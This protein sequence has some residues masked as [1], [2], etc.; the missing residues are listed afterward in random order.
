MC[1]SI[2]S[3]VDYYFLHEQP[4]SFISCYDVN[5]ALSGWNTNTLI[6][7]T[8]AR[9]VRYVMLSFT[10]LIH[11]QCQCASGVK[12]VYHN[13]AAIFGACLPMCVMFYLCALKRRWNWLWYQNK[14]HFLLIEPEG[15]RNILAYVRT[16]A[17]LVIFPE[18][19]SS[20]LCRYALE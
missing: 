18:P 16:G 5:N 1:D 2:P 15:S 14:V 3:T 13:Q 8:E 19:L 9:S 17:G 10:K 4:R 20:R 6:N 7:N 11:M 12:T